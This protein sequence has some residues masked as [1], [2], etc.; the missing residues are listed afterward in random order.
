MNFPELKS[1]T[2]I[3]SLYFLQLI[4]YKLFIIN[5]MNP[6]TIA[7][8]LLANLHSYIEL[9]LSQISNIIEYSKIIYNE[10]SFNYDLSFVFQDTPPSINIDSISTNLLSQQYKEDFVCA[11]STSDGNCLFHSASI[12]LYGSEKMSKRLRLASM[13]ELILNSYYYLQLDI[14]K[15]D[16]LYTDQAI[17]FAQKSTKISAYFFDIFK[18]SQD[19]AFCSQLIIYGLSSVL[20]REIQCIYPFQCN[21]VM[22]DI[23][24]SLVK[25]RELDYI[26]PIYIMW[27]C[28]DVSTFKKTKVAN[29][30]VPCFLKVVILFNS[31]FNSEF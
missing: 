27:T 4:L 12:A 2:Y 6:E 28:H 24:S 5:K 11:D 13:L 25:P 15:K 14:F 10:F 1:D 7:N 16:Y 21:Q 26:V 9:N 8:N 29:H 17:N 22:H 19:H 23:Y 20:K 3:N 30:F 31:I 18:M